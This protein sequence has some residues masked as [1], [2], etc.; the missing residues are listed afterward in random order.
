MLPGVNH[1]V[2]HGVD[3]RLIPPGPQAITMVLRGLKPVEKPAPAET[4]AITPFYAILKDCAHRKR[5]K[6]AVLGHLAYAI[7]IQREFRIYWF[8]C[9]NSCVLAT[10]S[11]NSFRNS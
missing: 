1:A 6:A 9:L 2:Q 10:V 7:V 8:W 5:L 3:V 4:V 11:K